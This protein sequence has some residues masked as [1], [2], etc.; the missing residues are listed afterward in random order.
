M[1]LMDDLDGKGYDGCLGSRHDGVRQCAHTAHLQYT[2]TVSYTLFLR[3]CSFI[4]LECSSQLQKYSLFIMAS[5]K[6]YSLP[7][8]P[9]AYDV[10]SHFRLKPRLEVILILLTSL[11]YVP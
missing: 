6:A 8:L 4:F 11:S 9:Y 1:T 5:P 2:F 7:A 10:Y 3:S